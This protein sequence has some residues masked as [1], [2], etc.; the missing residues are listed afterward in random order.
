[1]HKTDDKGAKKDQEQQKSKTYKT[2]LS[3]LP[4]EHVF[5]SPK[6]KAEK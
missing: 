1:M 3:F 2:A 5:V 6:L 4:K